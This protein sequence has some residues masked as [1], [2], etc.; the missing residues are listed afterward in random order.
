MKNNYENQE[1]E[2]ELRKVF[3]Q[4]LSCYF[5]RKPNIKGTLL[6]VGEQLLDLNNN[7]KKADES[8]TK[9]S[10]AI[11]NLTIAGTV[12]AGYKINI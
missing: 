6:F 11:K 8:S 10:M 12:I 1:T 7:L 9:L 5:G 4:N 2:E 3:Y